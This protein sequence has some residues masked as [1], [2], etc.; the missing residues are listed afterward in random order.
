MLHLHSFLAHDWTEKRLIVVITSPC[1]GERRTNEN[2]NIQLS[3]KCFICWLAASKTKKKSRL[4]CNNI[5]SKVLLPCCCQILLPCIADID[6]PH[7][8][9]PQSTVCV[10]GKNCLSF[11]AKRVPHPWRV[12]FSV[13][14]KLHISKRTT[15][16]NTNTKSRERESLY[17]W[18]VFVWIHVISE[19]QHN[20]VVAIQWQINV[21]LK[22]KF[23]I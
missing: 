22:G 5:A 19:C 20:F 10:C 23:I 2:L 3:I 17:E 12:A 6:P 18:C 14:N 21:L 9:S 16:D 8:H 7:C 11:L 13:Q 4:I 15:R 1:L